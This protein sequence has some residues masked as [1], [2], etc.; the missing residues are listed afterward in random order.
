MTDLNSISIRPKS[1]SRFLSIAAAI[2]LLLSFAGQLIKYWKVAEMYSLIRLFDVKMEYNIPA[3]FS[4]LLLFFAATLTG[5][6][7]TLKKKNHAVYVSHWVALAVI[8]LVASLDEAVS[9]HELLSRVISVHMGFNT[10]GLFYFSWVIGGIGFT[11]L[12]AAAYFMFWLHLPP[13]IRLLFLLA[14]IVFCSGALGVEMISGAYIEKYRWENLTVEIL[15][16]VEEALEMAG[17]IIFTFA[18]MKYLQD[19]YGVIRLRVDDA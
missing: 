15:A 13:R 4:S 19:N 10:G 17:A 3:F 14:A 1:V 2:L 18:L 8:F 11:L 6:I 16:T 5:V 9:L 7:A 12:F